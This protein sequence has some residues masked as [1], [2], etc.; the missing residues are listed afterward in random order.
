MKRIVFTEEANRDLAQA[1]AWFGEHS[2]IGTAGFVD[3]IHEALEKIAHLPLAAPPWSYA[4]KYR[5]LTLKRL[6]Y[7]IIYQV[8]DDA[9]RIAALIHTS[10][11][12]ILWL[13][14]LE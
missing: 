2:V 4:P 8:T 7:R 9:I 13:D 3:L 11:D 1:A 14:R 6:H 10:R 5:A 12:P